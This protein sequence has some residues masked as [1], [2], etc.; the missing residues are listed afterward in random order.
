[1][2][3]HDEEPHT[4]TK[5][6]PDASIGIG[7]KGRRT[8]RDLFFSRVPTT[9]WLIPGVPKH[10]TRLNGRRRFEKVLRFA[11]GTHLRATFSTEDNFDLGGLDN[12]AVRASVDT[13]EKHRQFDDT[14][15]EGIY[16]E[17]P[18]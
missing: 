7:P 2:E 18:C 5:A 16:S 1:V 12:F 8:D 6:R 14:F 11:R 4:R 10:H 9:P 13:E 17:K 15:T 3:K